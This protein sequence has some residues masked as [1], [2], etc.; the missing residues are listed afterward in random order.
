MS[1][2]LRWKRNNF[3]KVLHVTR[4]PK[5]ITLS[6]RDPRFLLFQNSHLII[7]RTEQE[8]SSIDISSKEKRGH[9][10]LVKSKNFHSYIHTLEK[11]VVRKTF[12]KSVFIQMERHSQLL[13]CE[14]R[15]FG[16][17]YHAW[18]HFCKVRCIYL[19]VCIYI[20]LHRKS[21]GRKHTQMLMVVNIYGQV[22]NNDM[23][24]SLYS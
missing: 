2:K 1:R 4:E 11:S 23:A 6:G 14:R 21:S 17:V 20:Y 12:W 18:F 19:C 9:I 13:Q 10:Q 8:G 7:F 15:K 24:D 22:D 16:K 3:L 5:R